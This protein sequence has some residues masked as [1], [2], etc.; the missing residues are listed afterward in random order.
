MVLAGVA[1][2]V[3]LV[4]SPSV[5]AHDDDDEGSN[6]PSGNVP[7]RVN[8]PSDSEIA[9]ATRDGIAGSRSYTS[10]LLN[11][12]FS[13]AN[14]VVTGINKK[15]NQFTGGEGPATGEEVVHP[16]APRHW[17]P[18]VGGFHAEEGDRI[19]RDTLEYIDDKEGDFQ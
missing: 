7:T 4:R 3:M 11:S 18:A 6:P 14:T 9:S 8:S 5:K 10:T 19:S 2:A 13:V 17:A 12:R 16:T 15:P 1:L